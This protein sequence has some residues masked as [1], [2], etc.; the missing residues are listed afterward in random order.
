MMALTRQR[1]D[2]LALP[3]VNKQC[4]QVNLSERRFG[5]HRHQL[6][7]I[8]FPICGGQFFS[9]FNLLVLIYWL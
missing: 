2:I 4:D 5:A 8:F 1:P 9:F 6:M 3:C 7:P